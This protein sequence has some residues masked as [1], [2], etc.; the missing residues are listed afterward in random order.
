MNDKIA[1]NIFDAGRKAGKDEKDLKDC[2]YPYNEDIDSEYNIWCAG[3]LFYINS[4]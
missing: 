1:K 4:Q 3:W 2:P